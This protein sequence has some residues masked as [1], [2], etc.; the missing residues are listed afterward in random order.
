MRSALV[1]RY[2]RKTRRFQ[3][4]IQ[5]PSLATMLQLQ[6]VFPLMVLE[7]AAVH[8]LLVP[9]K[10]LEV[11]AVQKQA[12]VLQLVLG[13]EVAQKQALVLQLVLAVKPQPPLA[14]RLALV[15][16]FPLE[17]LEVE[18]LQALQLQLL[19]RQQARVRP[20]R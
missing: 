9:P 6:V 15:L 18:F 17:S 7:V 5:L 2:Q 3:Y 10:V 4:P 16:A 14:V 1:L 8:L 20:A 19:V 11:A 12:L 13:E